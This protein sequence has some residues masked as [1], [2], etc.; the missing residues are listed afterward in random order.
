M[1]SL[2]KEQQFDIIDAFSST[3]RYRDDLVKID[4]IYFEQ[5]A[6]R[7]YAAE[8]QLSK[9]NASNTEAA[10][11]DLNLLVQQIPRLTWKW[12]SNFFSLLI[13]VAQTLPVKNPTDATLVSL[14]IL[15]YSRCPPNGS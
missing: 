6:Q 13:L 1:K 5:M 12:G 10:F 3:S 7:V 2:S 4:N 11:L 8:L 9:G 15:R 14:S